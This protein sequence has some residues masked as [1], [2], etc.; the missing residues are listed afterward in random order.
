MKYFVRDKSLI[1]KFPSCK[2]EPST[3]L[4]IEKFAAD[5]FQGNNDLFKVT[6]ETQEKGVKYIQ[7]QQ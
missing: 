3:V 2:Q 7:S 1:L 6:I 5:T 4:Q